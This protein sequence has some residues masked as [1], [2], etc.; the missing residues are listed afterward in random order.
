MKKSLNGEG[1]VY[2]VESENRWIHAYHDLMGKRHVKRY[3][4]RTEAEKAKRDIVTSMERGEYVEASV[5][6]VEQWLAIWLKEYAAPAIRKSTLT[7]NKRIVSGHLAPAFSKIKLQQLRNDDIQAFVNKQMKAGYAP[8][9]IRRQTAVLKCALH[10]AV[11]NNMIIRNPADSIKPPK[12]VQKEIE[13]LEPEE[14]LRLLGILPETTHGRAIR[15]ILGTGLRVSELCGLRWCDI[16]VEGFSIKQITYVDNGEHI[17]ESPKTRAG[18]RNIPLNDKLR[19]IL[20]LQRQQQRI[21]RLKVGSAWQGDEPCKGMQ[22]VFAT[23]LG[24]PADRNN[25]ARALRSCLKKAGLKSRGVHALRHTFATEWVRSGKD[26]RTLSEILGHTN[27]A[28]TMQTYVHS[29]TATKRKA[30]EDMAS[31]I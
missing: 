18:K 27:V 20:D 2:Y 9:T 21:E 8:S 26:I 4:T 12:L 13:F 1:S 11:V 23:S 25:I 7:V 17:A 5:I 19:S 15:F 16:M 14:I 30:M 29:S 22:P 3:K 28:F 6:T 24:L 31:L 10:Q